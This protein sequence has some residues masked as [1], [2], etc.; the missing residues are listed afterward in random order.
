MV[1]LND[2]HWPG[3]GTPSQSAWIVRPT[4]NVLSVEKSDAWPSRLWRAG[5]LPALGSS[6]VHRFLTDHAKR[7]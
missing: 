4:L 6:L 5:V 1:C 3:V 7:S 2:L